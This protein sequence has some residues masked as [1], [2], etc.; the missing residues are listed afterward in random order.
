MRIVAY[1]LL[2]LSLFSCAEPAT[3]KSL[4]SAS[5]QSAPPVDTTMPSVGKAL[6]IE[7]SGASYD[8]FVVDYPQ[9]QIA[10]YWKDDSGRNLLSLD[11]LKAH[12]EKRG[13]KL[14][15]ATNA[16]IYLENYAPQGLYI[17]NGRQLR[18]LDTKKKVSNANFY[19]QPNGIFC[20][21]KNKGHVLTTE[22]YLVRGDKI[23]RA[24]V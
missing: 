23:G 9:E 11:N 16:G 14:V 3:E 22:N 12:V 8:V 7:H 6:R 5:R 20:L 18:P 4:G 13:Q 2:A 10:L 1:L 19:M 17:E 15:F 21:T 24:H